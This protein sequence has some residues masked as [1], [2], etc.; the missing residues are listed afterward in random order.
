MSKKKLEQKLSKRNTYTPTN[1]PQ[2]RSNCDSVLNSSED[3][4][5]VQSLKTFDNIPDE[6]LTG[7]RTPEQNCSVKKT[8]VSVVYVL[9]KRGNSLMPTTPRKARKLLKKGEAYVVNRTPFTIKLNK[10][11]GRNLQETILGLDP[12]YEHIGVSVITEKK[13]LYSSEILPRIDIVKLNSERASY[14]KKRRNRKTWYR[15]ARFLNRKKGKGWL[16]PSIRHKLNTHI[17]IVEKIS[18]IVPINRLMVEVSD[19]DIQ[20]IKNPEIS[21]KEYQQ[22]E[23]LGFCNVRE[24]VLF[25]DN[26]VCQYC[27]GKSKDVIL[28]VHHLVSRQTGGDRS[29]NLIT[30]CKTC[31]EL[32]HKRLIKLD[33]IKI[34]KGFKAETSM[35][36][37]RYKIVEEL[38][39][40]FKNVEIIF[41]YDTKNKRIK[42]KLSKTH[43][44]DAFIIAGGTIQKRSQ[45]YLIKQVRKQN[46]KLYKGIRSHIKNTAKREIFGF[47]R[48]DKVKYNNK[49]CF[50]FGRRNRG[51]FDIRK[52]TGE[53]I[54]GDVKYTNLELLEKSRTLL[55][56]LN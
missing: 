47:Q 20:K 26:H 44:N 25:R 2:V 53:K 28:R 54:C 30:L 38:K 8:E 3:R 34:Y 4:N 39:K 13:E 6:A 27:K 50:I 16:A 42:L 23:Q 37:I 10:S 43:N 55:T 45:K 18:K 1:T 51:Y 22:G 14:K 32:F 5:S 7:K 40:R 35:N 21:G 17:K 33:K 49:E 36:I 41:G 24:Y 52:L 15:Q 11:V 19:F 48:Y 12:G 9:N 46:R 56:I 31:H 29:E